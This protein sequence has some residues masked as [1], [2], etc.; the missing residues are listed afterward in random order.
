MKDE[1][2]KS[3]VYHVIV[4]AP[5]WVG[6]TF[7]SASYQCGRTFTTVVGL[8]LYLVSKLPSCRVL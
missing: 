3:Y 8:V 6:G 7:L 1:T 5:H 2:I 4:V